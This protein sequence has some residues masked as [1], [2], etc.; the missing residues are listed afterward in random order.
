LRLAPCHLG[1]AHTVE[2][3]APDHSR[4]L[5]VG[6]TGWPPS[7]AQERS[8]STS[9]ESQRRRGGNSGGRTDPHRPSASVAGDRRSATTTRPAS[10][11]VHTC[12]PLLIVQSA[13]E[14]TCGSV[15]NTVPV[16]MFRGSP[17]STGSMQ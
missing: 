17:A 1:D 8:R 3:R 16:A 6:S 13:T 2:E 9:R 10:R 15:G 11:A 5:S 7:R 12:C 14:D 4:S